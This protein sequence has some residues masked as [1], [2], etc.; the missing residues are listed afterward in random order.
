MKKI[1]LA[2]A[3]VIGLGLAGLGSPQA[4]AA[5]PFGIHV[6]GGGLHVVG[7]GV[8]VDLGRVYHGGHGYP[9]SSYYPGLHYGGHYTSHYDRHPAQAIPHGNH[10]DYTPGHYDRH[11]TGRY[12]YSR[13]GHGR[14]GRR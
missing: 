6:S 7:G 14:Y 11:Q 13:G 2:L 10:Y 4:K 8:H 9:R 12:G 1:A 3:V 5:G